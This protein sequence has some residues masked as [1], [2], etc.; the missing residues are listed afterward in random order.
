M[1]VHTRDSGVVIGQRDVSLEAA[2]FAGNPAWRLV[3]TRTGLVPASET[4]FVASNLRP[5]NWYSAAR[6]ARLGA[7]FVGDTIF[8]AT[9]TP[10]G[11]QSL[12]LAG[13]PDLLV[14]QPMIE[15]L[16]PLL[17]LSAEWADS[18]AVLAVDMTAGYVIP[19]ALSVIGDEQV[20]LDS[21]VSRPAWVVTLRADARTIL[22][23]VDKESGDI[24]RVQQPLPAHV[25]TLLEYRR[26][27]DAVTA[28][29]D[30]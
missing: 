30:R 22:L 11:K 25:G 28:P 13:R 19:V 6:E 23:W 9:S 4:L 1:I 21:T 7:S 3:E 12:I 24:Y 27:P 26:R 2:T 18:A 8:G 17:P 20:V 15:M 10:A 16:V 14:S 29:P 5:L